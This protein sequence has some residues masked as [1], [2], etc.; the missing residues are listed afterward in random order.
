MHKIGSKVKIAKSLSYTGGHAC[1]MDCHLGETVV[2]VDIQYNARQNA[3][4][5]LNGGYWL[6]CRCKNGDT[7]V[8]DK[9][10]VAPMRGDKFPWDRF[11]AGEFSVRVN[12]MDIQNF[13]RRAG[14]RFFELSD[15]EGS[16]PV[17]SVYFYASRKPLIPGPILNITQ[18]PGK[19]TQLVYDWGT[20]AFDK[21]WTA[22]E[23]EQAKQLSRKLVVRLFDEGECSP[24]FYVD[25]EDNSVSLSLQFGY[26]HKR[27]NFIS[28]PS[29]GD[30]FNAD[31]G[32]C[33]CLCKATGTP[34]PEFIKNKNGEVKP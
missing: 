13:I 20:R 33:V 34:M 17:K 5:G 16:I 28:K 1:Q 27:G 25:Q 19:H 10:E 23:I 7:V 6:V 32:K 31:I 29:G 24:V 30:V 11:C 4:N 26:P 2:I 14:K 12:V 18:Y 8:L 15:F 3:W 9:T 22:E 21:I